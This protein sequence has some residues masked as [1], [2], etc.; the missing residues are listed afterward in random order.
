MRAQRSEGA[1]VVVAVGPPRASTSGAWAHGLPFPW[2]SYSPCYL[3]SG[4]P[5]GRMHQE[6]VI[7]CAAEYGGGCSNRPIRSTELWSIR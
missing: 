6:G 5:H 4:R 7:S 3:H 1:V 2:R